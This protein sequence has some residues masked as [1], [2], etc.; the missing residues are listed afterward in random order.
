MSFAFRSNV[1]CDNMWTQFALNLSRIKPYHVLIVFLKGLW[2]KT[3][4]G[5]K[6][7]RTVNGM[8]C[9]KCAMTCAIKIST[10]FK[11]EEE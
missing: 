1:I 10:K 6:L 11:E 8:S 5:V 7:M 2:A 3:I 4:D 9:L